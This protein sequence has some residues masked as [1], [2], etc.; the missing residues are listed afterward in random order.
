MSLLEL[1]TFFHSLDVFAA[2]RGSSLVE[3]FIRHV[4]FL[5]EFSDCNIRVSDLSDS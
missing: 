5:G 2:L 3:V 4:C 1:D